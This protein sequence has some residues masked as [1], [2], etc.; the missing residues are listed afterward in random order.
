MGLN[1]DVR[2][3]GQR[4]GDWDKGKGTGVEARGLG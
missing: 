4:S 2:G 1:V 3:L